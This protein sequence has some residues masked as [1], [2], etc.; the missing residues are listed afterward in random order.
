MSKYNCANCGYNTVRKNDYSRHIKSKKHL[1]KVNKPAPAQ[2]GLSTVSPR[3]VTETIFECE[4]CQSKF[5]RLCNLTLHQKICTSGNIEKTLKELEFNTLK[6]KVETMQKQINTYESMLK[7]F[8]TPQTI[9]YFNFIV[10]NY[11][12][13]PALEGQQSY[14]GIIDAKTMTLIEVVTMY[15]NDN[16]LVSFIGDYI[17]R[18]YKKEKSKE[19]SMWPAACSLRSLSQLMYLD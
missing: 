13:T 17:I 19:Q 2:H 16:K 3:T 15:Y 8:T 14:A 1:E 6:D 5:K 7:S 12:N 18:L 10:Q 4:F 11:P 9:N